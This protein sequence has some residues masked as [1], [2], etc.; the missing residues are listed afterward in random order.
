MMLIRK[1]KSAG[2][3]RLKYSLI[4]QIGTKVFQLAVAIGIGG[5]TA[6]YLGPSSLGKLSYVVALVGVFSPLGSL[7]VNGSLAALLCE[8]PPRPGLVGSALCIELVGT[9]VIALGLIPF[10]LLSKDP[11]IAALIALAL[12]AS[13]FNSAEVFETALLNQQRGTV[14][15]RIGLVQTFWGSLMTVV[16]LTA[17]APLLLFGALQPFQSLIRACSLIVGVRRIAIWESIL[18]VNFES[19]KLLI[20]R[21]WPLLLAG[22]SVMLYMKSDQLMLQWLRGPEEVGQYAVAVRVAESLYFLPVVLAQ[23]F[24]PRLGKK[25]PEINQPLPLRHFYRSAWFLGV[26]M[27]AVSVLLLPP[28]IPLIFG[29]QYVSARMA[30]ILLGPASFAV[31]TGCASTAWL[32]V[33]GFQKIIAQSSAVG[34]LC[35]VFLNL[36]LI[37]VFGMSGAAI[38]TSISQLVSVYALALVS[39]DTRANTCFLANPF[40]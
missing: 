3:D 34:A 5:W 16:A 18:E 8:E 25:N 24:L 37:P 21:G 33:N 1:E 11:V 9:F 4:A 23:T 30:L 22:F 20:R 40:S 27:T 14:V 13:L 32:N 15:A 29:Q 12:I 19:V 17:H 35:N 38:A 36:W 2:P 10:A 39:K 31:S 26:A 6:R 28:L 7:G